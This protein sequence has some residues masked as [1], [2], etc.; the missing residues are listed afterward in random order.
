MLNDP[1]FLEMKGKITFD[2]R[3]REFKLVANDTIF[4]SGDVAWSEL[5]IDFVSWQV[6]V[7]YNKK[8]IKSCSDPRILKDNYYFLLFCLNSRT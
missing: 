2:E 7:K 6:R 3:G 1:F 4:S 8:S 5:G